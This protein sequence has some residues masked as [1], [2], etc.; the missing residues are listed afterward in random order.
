MK[1]YLWCLTCTYLGWNEI[2]LKIIWLFLET[3]ESGKRVA[4]EVWFGGMFRGMIRGMIRPTFFTVYI[5]TIYIYI[6]ILYQGALSYTKLAVGARFL[7]GPTGPWHSKARFG[8]D[9]GMIWGMTR[10]ETVAA[11]KRRTERCQIHN[12]NDAHLV[13]SSGDILW[14]PWLLP[15]PERHGQQASK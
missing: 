4:W 7:K 1:C 2:W 5:K 11:K 12:K 9:S 14:Q 8:Y 3:P 6:S 13:R 15:Y 10:Q